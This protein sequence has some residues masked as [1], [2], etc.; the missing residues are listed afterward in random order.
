MKRQKKEE[1]KVV[2]NGVERNTKAEVEN[3]KQQEEKNPR[4][5][6]NINNTTEISKDRKVE[7]RESGGN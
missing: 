7:G 6:G 1:D 3:D 5:D 4:D 2:W